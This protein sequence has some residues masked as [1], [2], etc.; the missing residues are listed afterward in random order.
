MADAGAYCDVHRAAKHAQYDAINRRDDAALAMAKQIRSSAQWTLV[1]KIVRAKNPICCDPFRT[2]GNRPE[3]TQSTH[4]IEP[5]AERPDLAFDEANLRG[6]CNQCHNRLEAI[7]RSGK[8]TKSL[9][10]K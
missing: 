8:S 5:L 2:H 1:S 9:F 4:H 3:P 7:E 6:V 10:I